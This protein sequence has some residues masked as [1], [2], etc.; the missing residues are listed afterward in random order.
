M[1]SSSLWLLDDAPIL[2]G[3][4]IFALRL[5]RFASRGS[6]S[7]RVVC[8]DGELARR[9]AAEG[10]ERV[11]ASFPDLGPRGVTRWPGAVLQTRALLRRAGPDAIALG[12]TA[13]TQAYLTAAAPLIR[14]GP[15]IVQ[16]LHE[17]ET[18]ARASG[19]FAFRR[20]GALVAMGGNVAEACRRALPGV[21][22]REANLFLDPEETGEPPPRRPDAGEPAIG[23]LTRLI[24]AKGVLELVDELA[25][26]RSWSRATIAGHA[27][28]PGYA[29]AVEE[30]IAAHG[31]DDRV[32]LPGP[33]ADLRSFLSEIDVLVAPSTGTEGQ[34]F[35][36]V[37]ALWHD[38]PCLVRRG[39][40]SASDFEGLPVLPFAG[41]VE[42]ERGLRE[43]ASARVPLDLV[44]RRFGPEQAL[45][46][47]IAAA[48]EGRE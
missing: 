15:T 7:F 33:V 19:R 5:A 25:A 13:R 47:I 28:D 21:A 45:E 10:I 8:P 41:A 24:P 38:R 14:R 26:A 40:F 32:L 9:C 27:Q 35:G 44:R 12:N 22:V 11:S 3:A 17:Q 42:L 43:L 29:R 16:V 36:I 46:A 2:G 23:V 34:G 6:A 31:L 48:E 18:L 20:V 1:E 39:A 30:R 4:E 37:E